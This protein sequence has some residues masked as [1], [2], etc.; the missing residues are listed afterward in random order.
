MELYLYGTILGFALSY[1][2]YKMHNGWLRKILICMFFS[3]GVYQLT[4]LI[5]YLTNLK[6]NTWYSYWSRVPFLISLF[7][8]LLYIIKDFKNRHGR[9]R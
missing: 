3:F 2:F 7:I 4:M 9:L 8:L 6:H 5:I 1:A